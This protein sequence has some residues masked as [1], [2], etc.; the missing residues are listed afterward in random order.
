MHLKMIVEKE[1]RPDCENEL[2]WEGRGQPHI[3]RVQMFT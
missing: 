3:P 1:G 2:F